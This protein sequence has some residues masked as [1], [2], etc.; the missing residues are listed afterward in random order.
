MRLSVL[1][2]FPLTTKNFSLSG[3]S[4][5]RKI[6]RRRAPSEKFKKGKHGIDLLNATFAMKL[7]FNSWKSPQT[8][9]S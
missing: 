7:C 4:F 5:P 6:L 2:Q 9:G 1:L 3:K 8:G